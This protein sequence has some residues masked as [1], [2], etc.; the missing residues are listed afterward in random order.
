MAGQPPIQHQR[1][2]T[3][4]H[5]VASHAG[6]KQQQSVGGT[7]GWWDWQAGKLW[8]WEKKKESDRERERKREKGGEADQ[9]SPLQIHSRGSM[10]I[11]L[12]NG[13][14]MISRPRLS[15]G[16]SAGSLHS[17]RIAA[18]C[19]EAAD[20]PE[21]PPCYGWEGD[22]ERNG[23][24]PWTQ[25]AVSRMKRLSVNVFLNCQRNNLANRHEVLR[26]GA[27]DSESFFL[28][29]S[30]FNRNFSPAKFCV[31][32]SSACWHA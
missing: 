24:S 16:H 17:Q 28:I 19:G 2:P 29:I 8:G 5:C 10:W 22:T 3:V 25:S 18:L 13:C 30:R 14:L 9:N 15:V 31:L 20:V 7:G 11:H 4:D 32:H 26:S 1:Q 21:S 27:K 12:L 23:S 6:V